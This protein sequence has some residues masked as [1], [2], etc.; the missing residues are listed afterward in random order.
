MLEDCEFE[1]SLSNAMRPCPQKE[2][3]DKETKTIQYKK[4]NWQNSAS[5]Y[6]L[7]KTQKNRNR[8]KKISNLEKNV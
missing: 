7:K 5:I 8:E 6:D 1:G 4:K 3:K 2:K